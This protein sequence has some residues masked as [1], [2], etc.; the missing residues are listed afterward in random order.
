MIYSYDFPSRHILA[1]VDCDN[2]K[3]LAVTFVIVVSVNYSPFIMLIKK[4]VAPNEATHEKRSAASQG[5]NCSSYQIL[6]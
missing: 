2:P 3:S 5:Y 6:S 1:I 4:C